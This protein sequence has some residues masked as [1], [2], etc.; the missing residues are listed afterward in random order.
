[1]AQVWSMSRWDVLECFKLE[2]KLET[3]KFSHVF[4]LYN[5]VIS[6]RFLAARNKE[7]NESE[8]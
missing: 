2:Q 1:M 5:K 4:D 8:K 7:S 6:S 3:M